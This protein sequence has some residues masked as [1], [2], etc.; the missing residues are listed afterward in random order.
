MVKALNT[1]SRAVYGINQELSPVREAVLENQ[2][3][4]EIFILLPNVSG[5]LMGAVEQILVDDLPLSLPAGR[6]GI[7]AHV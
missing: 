3:A 7:N 5:W 4:I 6:I 1:T 2:A